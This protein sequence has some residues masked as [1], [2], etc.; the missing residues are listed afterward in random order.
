[1]YGAGGL[2]LVTLIAG[3][4]A[5]DAAAALVG[6]CLVLTIVVPVVYGPRWVGSI[7]AQDCLSADAAGLRYGP[8]YFVPWNL[9]E[10]AAVKRRLGRPRVVL[11]AP[12]WRRGGVVA[13]IEHRRGLPL[14][15]YDRNWRDDTEL[16]SALR[17]HLPGQS[18]VA[19]I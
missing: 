18:D 12:G 10:R 5:G 4:A 7:Y 2:A 14:S 17:D 13:R 19:G 16:V 8:K 9:V 1:M 3:A 6:P 11:L 15:D